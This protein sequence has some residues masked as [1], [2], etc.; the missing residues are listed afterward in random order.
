M[1]SKDKQYKVFLMID[2][3]NILAKGIEEGASDVHINVGM[4][5]VLRKNT[6]LVDM[7]FPPVSSEEAKEWSFLWLD[8]TDSKN[9]RKTGTSISR[10]A[11]RTGIDS[12]STHTGSVTLLLSH[13]E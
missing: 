6:E 1:L 5:P 3:K 4:P 10:Q 11:L 2:I 9:F 13:L 12:A 8:L 7:E